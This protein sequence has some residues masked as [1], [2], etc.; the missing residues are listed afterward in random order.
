MTPGGN[1]VLSRLHAEYIALAIAE[2]DEQDFLDADY[3]ASK[4]IQVDGG[5][6]AG[7]DGI[8]SSKSGRETA[9]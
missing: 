9:Q 5:T 4:A 3:F 7:L 2:N 6:D 1:E 8:K